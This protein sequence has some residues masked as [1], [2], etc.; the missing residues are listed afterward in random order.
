M[1]YQIGQSVSVSCIEGWRVFDGDYQIVAHT[2]IDDMNLMGVPIEEYFIERKQDELFKQ[3]YKEGRMFYIMK[4]I[5]R[6]NFDYIDVDKKEVPEEVMPLMSTR[7]RLFQPKNKNVTPVDEGTKDVEDKTEAEADKEDVSE[8]TEEA[9]K[10][11][12]EEK[13]AKKKK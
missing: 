7:R 12:Q 6:V 3:L 2:L 13:T 9:V 11:K 1:Y 4:K 8:E 5:V 10:E